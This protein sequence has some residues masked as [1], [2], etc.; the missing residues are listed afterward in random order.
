M[1]ASAPSAFPPRRRKSAAERR[2]QY[3]RADAR[4]LH[5]LL[6]SLDVLQHRGSQPTNVGSTL[7]SHLRATQ[8]ASASVASKSLCR[9]FLRGYCRLGEACRFVH[10]APSQCLSSGAIPFQPS[11]PCFSSAE[12]VYA[13][14]VYA[15]TIPEVAPVPQSSRSTQQISSSSNN[16]GLSAHDD[17]PPR[18]VSF[19]NVT[20]HEAPIC[21]PPSTLST[22]PWPSCATSDPSQ[23]FQ[24]NEQ[25]FTST[26]N[27]RLKQSSMAVTVTIPIPSGTLHTDIVANVKSSSIS[28]CTKDGAV[29]LSGHLPH[30]IHVKTSS[31]TVLLLER[32]PR[33]GSI[34][35][36]VSPA[37][38]IT[39]AKQSS[40]EWPQLFDDR[41]QY[42]PDSLLPLS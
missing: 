15:P 31:W 2:L 40:L 3:D 25:T 1:A 37:L 28:F 41:Y 35:G 6:K 18:K 38:Y 8:A 30:P 23:P 26:T 39:L 34:E 29:L 10:T 22:T 42:Q 11:A 13:P 21:A 27:F 36:F 7:V 9:H 17:R 14:G 24:T 4:V 32:F 5:R 33:N 20:V 16:V 19:G 12:V